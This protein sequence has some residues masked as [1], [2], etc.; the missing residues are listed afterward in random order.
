ML[1]FDQALEAFYKLRSAR[2]LS[3][4]VVAFLLVISI[5]LGLRNFYLRSEVTLL[6]AKNLEYSNAIDIQNKAIKEVAAHAKE[7]E[8]ALVKAA[9]KN[10][11]LQDELAR[12]KRDWQKTPI[13]GSCDQIMDQ[14]ME[15][16]K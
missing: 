13:T 12:R 1:E 15:G 14:I 9:K 3:V 10:L 6:K 16:W 5:V 4:V 7:Q 11:D 2:W 8:D